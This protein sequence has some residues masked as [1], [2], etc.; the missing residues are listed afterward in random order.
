MIATTVIGNSYVGRIVVHISKSST[1][2]DPLV[3]RANLLGITIVRRH[4]RRKQPN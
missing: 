3:T 1:A 2:D 4:P